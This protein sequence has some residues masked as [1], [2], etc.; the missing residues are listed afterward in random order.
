VSAENPVEATEAAEAAPAV[1]LSQ[2]RTRILSIDGK[3]RIFALEV[4][5]WAA[6]ERMAARKGKRLNVL[7]GTLLTTSNT[8]SQTS[9]LRAAAVTWLLGEC[10]LL[11]EQI[12][13][14]M[15][16]ILSAIPA[17]AVAMT[18]DQ[19]VIAQN[20]AFARLATETAAEAGGPGSGPEV[21]LRL[22]VAPA[23]LIAL[24]TAESHRAVGAP[25]TL[26][27]ARTKR[28]GIMNTAIVETGGTPL[29][30]CVVRKLSDEP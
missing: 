5:L 6:L 4:P 24:L 12:Q 28:S 9:H 14:S 20:S 25:F 23:R 27:T 16:G 30:L 7:I 26:R 3:R 8:E 11:R 10:D 21:T 1:A 29:L 15:R 2:R 13:A 18:A 17:P 22:D 19:Q